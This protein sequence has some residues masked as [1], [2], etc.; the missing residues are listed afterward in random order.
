MVL[1]YVFD[2]T[3]DRGLKVR[4]F[5][6]PQWTTK[7]SHFFKGVSTRFGLRTIEKCFLLNPDFLFCSSIPKS[8]S[9]EH[10][11]TARPLTTRIIREGSRVPFASRCAR[12]SA[13]AVCATPTNGPTRCS[14]IAQFLLAT[15]YV[16]KSRKCCFPHVLKGRACKPCKGAC[17]TSP[18]L[19]VMCM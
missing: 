17:H 2:T 7:C 9:G 1:I 3:F 4:L 14:E 10:Q 16:G 13:P 19:M 12:R 18:S 8:S 6:S 15:L 11:R 5:C